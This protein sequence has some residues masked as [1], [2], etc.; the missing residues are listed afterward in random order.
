MQGKD[1]SGQDLRGRS[2]KNQDLTAADFTGCD[3]RGVDF[4]GADLL[5][6]K[7]CDARFGRTNKASLA[8]LVFQL[9]LGVVVGFLVFVSAAFSGWLGEEVLKLF[10]LNSKTNQAI[11]IVIYN[12]LFAIV[13]VLAMVRQRWSYVVW[14][15]GLLIAVAVAVAISVLIYI[16]AGFYLGRRA[17]NKEESH[18]SIL[19]NWS[20]KLACW[21]GTEFSFATLENCDFNN[22]DLK[23]A[24]FKDAKI[25]NCSFRNA[26][27]HHLCLTKDTPLETKQVRELVVNA[28]IIS[29]DFEFLNLSGLDFSGLDLQGFNFANANISFTCFSGCNLNNAD[30]SETNAI[31]TNFNHSQMTGSIISNWNTD[32]RTQLEHINCRYVY[33]K[34]DKT[35]RNPPQG[36]FKEEEFSKLYQEISNTVDFIAHTPAELQALLRAIEK[37]K[38]EGGG[39][40]IQQMERKTDSV[41]LRVQSED[42]QQIDKEAIYNEVNQQK[43]LELKALEAEY[44]HKLLAQKVEHLEAV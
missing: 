21:R 16:I 43:E 3:L 31:G 34:A 7:F 32:T 23:Y 22:A 14:F 44:K 42:D 28:N 8:L 12:A 1:F 38:S 10:D 26:K 19:R 20:L 30:L 41:V 33:L 9:L 2:F 25:K 24:R 40:F 18:L 6:V 11:F 15:C 37:I 5:N 29:Q 35:E 13:L 4:S 27:N 36:E 17:N 39:I